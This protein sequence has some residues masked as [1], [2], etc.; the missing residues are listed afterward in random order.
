MRQVLAVSKPRRFPSLRQWSQWGRVATGGE[1]RA[2]GGLCAVMALCLAAIGAR[3]VLTHQV[4]T[5]AVGGE[6]VEALVGEPQFINPLYAPANDVDA[7]IARLVYAGLLRRDAAGALQPDM[8]ESWK[9]SEDGKVYTFTLRAD[10]KSTFMSG[11]AT[12]RASASMLRSTE[13]PNATS[14]TSARQ[15]TTPH[16]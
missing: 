6:Y 10:A 9:V 11:P 8:A 7:D 13:R 2:L 12:A 16:A 3:F 15:T 5:P 14:S 4:E 1:K